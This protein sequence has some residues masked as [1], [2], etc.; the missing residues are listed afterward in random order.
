MLASHEETGRQPQVVGIEAYHDE[1]WGHAA[2]QVLRECCSLASHEAQ[3]RQEHVC[4]E[5]YMQYESQSLVHDATLLDFND[6][7]CLMAS[8]GSMLAAFCAGM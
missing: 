5:G 3:R 2:H 4:P 8:M 6:Y 7:S 1:Q